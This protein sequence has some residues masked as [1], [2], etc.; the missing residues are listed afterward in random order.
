MVDLIHQKGAHLKSL[1]E[2]WLDT[3]TPQGKLLFAIFA[4]ISQFERD[5]ISERTKESL[6]S[7]RARGRKVGRPSIPQKDVEFALKLPRKLYWD[8]AAERFKND[9]EANAMLSR[10]QRHPYHI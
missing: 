4:D 6:S 10:V 8:L 9:D 5:I 7:A 2:P 1:K 3:T